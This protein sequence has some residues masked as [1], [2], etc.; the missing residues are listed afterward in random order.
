MGVKKME[1]K[2]RG[3]TTTLYS[4]GVLIA[5]IMGVGAAMGSSWATNEWLSLLLVVI[6]LIVGFYNISAK[7][8]L[9]FLVGT[10]AL[11]ICNAVA[12]LTSLNALIPKLGTF[13]AV[14]LANFTTVVAVAGVIVAF[15]A[16]YEIAK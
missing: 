10:V 16:V 12:N 4:I 1:R 13:V 7:E 2:S 15:R 11:I 8:I 5:L 6:G 9:S 3:L 14:T